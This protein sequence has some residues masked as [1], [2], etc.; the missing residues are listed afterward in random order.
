LV[1]ISGSKLPNTALAS[2]LAQSILNITS[3]IGKFPNHVAIDHIKKEFAQYF[4]DPSQLRKKED[5]KNNY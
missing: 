5:S 4:F 2:D 1:N 3:Q